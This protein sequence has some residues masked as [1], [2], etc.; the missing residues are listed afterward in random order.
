MKA[1]RKKI[2]I[3]TELKTWSN[4]KGYITVHYDYKL[5]QYFNIWAKL[6]LFLQ[7]CSFVNT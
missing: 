5:N 4:N 6:K 7:W 2:H 1:L 3:Q